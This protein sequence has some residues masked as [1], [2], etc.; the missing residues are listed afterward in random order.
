MTS[1]WVLD[2]FSTSGSDDENI[3]SGHINT[4][5]NNNS[6]TLT[7]HD[8]IMPPTMFDYR[9]IGEGSNVSGSNVSG[10]NVS[11]SN[12]SGSNVSGSNVSGS[13]VSGYDVWTC[14]DIPPFE[15]NGW[16]LESP[17]LSEDAYEVPSMEPINS[18]DGWEL[19]PPTRFPDLS[20][21]AIDRPYVIENEGSTYID[22][23]D[24]ST[25]RPR[26]PP[27]SAVPPTLSQ[28]KTPGCPFF[29]K[30]ID[31]KTRYNDNLEKYYFDM[32]DIFNNVTLGKSFSDEYYELINN[33]VCTIV[34]GCSVDSVP[35]NRKFDKL[36]YSFNGNMYYKTIVMYDLGQYSIVSYALL[37]WAVHNPEKV[38]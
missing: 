18:V 19:E 38:A 35:K 15:H 25:P 9:G 27:P 32:E 13:N 6:W 28:T 1:Q 37:D 4:P 22:P 14:N 24:T 29:S 12:V 34:N 8:G 26:P 17:N 36:V 20:D 7:G 3:E 30:S 23:I 16:E 33:H 2:D 5:I 10:S 31:V 11:G 21:E